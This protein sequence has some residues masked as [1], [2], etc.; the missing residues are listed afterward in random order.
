[1]RLKSITLAPLYLRPGNLVEPGVGHLSSSAMSSLR[2]PGSFSMSGS[3]EE[4]DSDYIPTTDPED[5]EMT[6]DDAEDS[7]DALD[8]E[9]RQALREAQAEA[10]NDDEAD[11]ALRIA[12]DG[13]S[14]LSSVR[15]HTA[16]SV[17]QP[18]RNQQ[19][20]LRRRYVVPVYPPV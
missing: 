8:A 18:S 12:L 16:D 9:G 11:E 2:F 19:Y 17:T 10:E 7:D 15:R 6:Q 14:V 20:N 3:E 1:M 5:A 13:Q 4:G